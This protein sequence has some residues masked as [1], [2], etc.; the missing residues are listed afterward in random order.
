V[1]DGGNQVAFTY[2]SPGQDGFGY[3]AVQVWPPGVSPEAPQQPARHEPSAAYR[4]SLVIHWQ[5][6][7]FTTGVPGGGQ[8]S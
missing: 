8:D 3:R 2:E 7:S 1:R 6:G 5:D 4:S